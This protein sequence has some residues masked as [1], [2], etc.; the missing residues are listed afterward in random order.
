MKISEQFRDRYCETLGQ[1]YDMKMRR[2]LQLEQD[3]N[4]VYEHETV[5]TVATEVYRAIGK[6]L[7]G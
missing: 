2:L 7:E 6:Q 4:M 5:D 1:P 3:M